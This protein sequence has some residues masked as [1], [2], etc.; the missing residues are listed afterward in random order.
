MTIRGTRYCRLA[1]SKGRG[2]KEMKV[3]T[4]REFPI[5]LHAYARGAKVSMNFAMIST[6]AKAA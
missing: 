6:R 3:P 1:S 4:P 2:E 5:D